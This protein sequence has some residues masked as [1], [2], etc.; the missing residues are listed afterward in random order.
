MTLTNLFS[1]KTRRDKLNQSKSPFSSF[2]VEQ[3]N[4]GSLLRIS[5]TVS[6]ETELTTLTAKYRDYKF[7]LGTF[8]LQEPSASDEWERRYSTEL[9]L[10]EIATTISEDAPELFEAYDLGVPGTEKK[11]LKLFAGTPW[12]NV[13]LPENAGSGPALVDEYIEYPLG[14]A[15]KNS[16]GRLVTFETEHGQL[17]PYLNRGRW[18]SIALDDPPQPRLRVF[19][20]GL[21]I[22]HGRLS[23]RGFIDTGH[24]EVLSA[25]LIILG[26]TTGYS[27][28]AK[29]TLDL[30]TSLTE[31]RFGHRTYSFESAYD[32]KQDL[33]HL[34]DD[35]VDLYIELETPQYEEPLRKRI[36]ISRYLVRRQAQADVIRR[37]D[38]AI[39]IVP[40]YTFKAKYPSLQF[41]VFKADEYEYLQQIIKRGASKN[42]SRG[43]PVWVLGEV[44]YK[45]QDNGMW[46][47]KYLRDKHPEI[48]AYY[49]LD[50]DSP[51]RRNLAGYESHVLDFRSKAHLDAL[52]VAERIV[53]THQPLQ[54]YPTRDR[55]FRRKLKGKHV[56]LQ[57][58]ITAAKWIAPVNGRNASDFQT[59]LV[60]V[61]SER[62]KEF[63][64]YDC[65]YS[66]SQVAVTG[67]AR[68]DSLFE[69]DIHVKKEQLLIM[70]TWRPWLQNPDAFKDSEYF[71]RWVG[72]LTGQGLADLKD[73]YGMEVVLCLH[74]NM[75][76]YSELFASLGLRVVLQGEVD[77]QHLLKESAVMLTDYSSVAFDFAFLDKPVVFYQFDPN[78]FD[79]PHADPFTE[80]PGP[81]VPDEASTLKHLDHIF[82]RGAEMDPEYA[83]RAKR[84]LENR[85]SLNRE[86]IYT[87]ISRLSTKLEIAE[88]FKNSE[89]V[90]TVTKQ[91]KKRPFYKS[92][93]KGIYRVF[94]ML[95]M[96]SDVIVFESDLARGFRD[97]PKAIYDELVSQGDDRRKVVVS[98]PRVRLYDPNTVVVKR[99]SLGFAWYL[100]RAKYWVNNQNFPEYVTRRRRGIYIQTWHGTPLKRMFLD[101]ENFFGRDPGYIDRVKKMAAQWNT[102]VSPS[103]F[104]TQ[105]LRSSYQYTGPAYELGYPR[106]DVLSRPEKESLGAAVRSGLGIAPEKFVVLYA[107]TFRDNKPTSRGRFAFEWPFDPREFVAELG[108]QVVLL[109]RTHNLVSTKVVIPDEVA[110][111]VI[112]VSSF[113]EMNHL[114]LASDMLVTDYSSSFFDFSVLQ[115]PIAFY[116]YDLEDYRDSVRGFYL[117]YD[118]ELPGPI[119]GN[120]R[121][122]YDEVNKQRISTDE[123]RRPIDKGF[124]QRFA[125][126][127]DGDAAKRVITELLS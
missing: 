54:L 73:N 108:E 45:A 107:P 49:V 80:L 87:A 90:S 35:V 2:E 117:D 103:E 4:G 112:D 20:D 119:V 81:V 104:T 84:F 34:D 48:D 125:P 9:S 14:R 24:V 115:R 19:N 41:E 66:D 64:V 38:E 77:V 94:R 93:V 88:E 3:S 32:F 98:N 18:L 118:T 74:P 121:A 127:E 10:D 97:N 7:V 28:S 85:D 21:T 89:A 27:A 44:R 51:E 33:E 1:K 22:K 71:Q 60:I 29:S 124:L 23:I 109:I 11:R 46:L 13:D 68:F 102:L 67:F 53:G 40:Y 92:F 57:H 62:E 100:A 52:L 37:G 99:H 96:R 113:P 101:Q 30:N 110:K 91:L 58:G 15:E 116:A 36:G 106:N 8:T 31:E 120:A 50:K 5:L 70:P 65:G 26:R 86:R 111:N 17:T 42:L 61:A 6:S 59:D 55:R 47:F 122:L 72:L 12:K 82:S 123:T 95:P 83:G 16:V 114:F 76:Q 25:N 78:E 75:Q 43:K 63:F 39:A 69:N 56:F 79:A 105:A 126:H